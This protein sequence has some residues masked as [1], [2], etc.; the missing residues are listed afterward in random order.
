MTAATWACTYA[1]GRR[2]RSSEARGG[3][4]AWFV[5]APAGVALPNSDSIGLVR[6]PR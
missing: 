1:G 6:M 2:M 3:A 4:L 5:P